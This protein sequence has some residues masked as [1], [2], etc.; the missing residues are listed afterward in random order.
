MFGT[1]LTSLG[2]MHN[3]LWWGHWMHHEKVGG[4]YG[5]LSVEDQ[6]RDFP[7]FVVDFDRYGT[8]AQNA[9]LQC[10]IRLDE[11]D[12]GIVI[13]FGFKVDRSVPQSR[14]LGPLGALRGFARSHAGVP[15]FGSRAHGALF[16]AIERASSSPTSSDSTS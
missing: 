7:D 8:E 2:C 4:H 9:W 3:N 5:S 13:G 1:L 10:P 6:Q 14:Q 11:Y 16:M 15:W 12:K